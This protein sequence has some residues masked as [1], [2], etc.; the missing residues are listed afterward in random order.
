[1]RNPEAKFL[2]LIV[3]FI[4]TLTAQAGDN[5]TIT[6]QGR[7][8]NASGAPIEALTTFQFV[9]R[10]PN[11]CILWAENQTLDL[12]GSKGAFSVVIGSGSNLSPGIHSFS[13]IF[14][15]ESTLTSLAGCSSGSTYSP[16]PNDDRTLFV[17]FDDGTGPQTMAGMPIKAVP[18]ASFAN[19]SITVQTLL[20]KILDT[21]LAP[22]AAQVLRFNSVSDK[23]EAKTLVASDISGLGGA[24]TLGVGTVSS[25]VAAGNDSRFPSVACLVGEKSRWDGSAWVCELDADSASGG[26]LLTL[27]G[28]VTG[29]GA[30]TIA[31]TISNNSITTP[32]IFANPGINR[33]VATDATTG[34]TLVPLVCP[35]DQLLVW[36]LTDG[37][38]CTAQTALAVGSASIAVNISGTLAVSKGGTGVGSLPACGA[39][40]A[41]KFDGASWSCISIASGAITDLTGD[42]AASGTGTVAATISADAVTSGKILDG[43]IVNADINAAAGIVDTKLATISTSGKVSNSATTATS[44]NTV[45]AIVARDGSG[46]FSAGTI[47]ATFSG[48]GSAL[49][50]L[51]AGDVS[52]GTL[53]LTRGGTG[54]TTQAGAANAILPSQGGQATKV[55]T[56]DGSNVSWEAAAGGSIP[57]GAVMA[58]NLASCPTGWTSLAGAAGRIIVGVGNNGTNSYALSASGGSDNITLSVAQLPAHTH[59]VDPPATGTDTQG[60]HSHGFTDNTSNNA[61]VEG[62]GGDGRISN[63]GV[64]SVGNTTGAAGSH[65]HAVDIGA[66]ASGSQG[67]GSAI[68]IRQAYLALLYCQKN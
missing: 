51:D 26:A 43:A 56:T 44:A 33:L 46:N 24:A 12:R 38:Q 22:T 17:S 59:T 36:H 65:S 34:S 47:T 55:L 63:Y 8:T 20:G 32:K 4:F 45:S 40:E 31:T 52:S 68:D 62:D 66:F 54:A 1:M 27:T 5:S 6:Y 7:I 9:V 10:A 60:N 21:A 48:D 57:A 53:P 23:W 49:T 18:F 11:N 19:S 29:V 28:H 25:S 39:A 35:T 30:G 15:N 50:N 13:Q 37:W 64:T 41:L 3:G 58:F 2:L 42:V 61:N 16:A 14:Y 67:S